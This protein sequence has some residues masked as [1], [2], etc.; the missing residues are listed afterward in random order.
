[1]IECPQPPSTTTIACV[2]D[3]CSH[4][5]TRLAGRPCLIGAGG[6]ER[7]AGA[8]CRRCGRA[9]ISGSA[10][11]KRLRSETARHA[12]AIERL[13][14]PV[15]S[16]G[17]QG[18]LRQRKQN[19]RLE[20]VIGDVTD[21]DL[22]WRSRPR[23]RSGRGKCRPA[24]DQPSH[25]RTSR[26]SSGER[27]RNLIECRTCHGVPSF[28]QRRS[29]GRLPPETLVCRVLAVVSL[30]SYRLRIICQRSSM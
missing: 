8:E 30:P 4:T 19:V 17:A 3:T 15:C 24:T 13:E 27:F 12:A 18:A 11:E 28:R 29:G 20:R 26:P 14:I 7:A 10:I 23:R 16:V 6:V 9:G 5:E 1:M 21:A 25:G 22:R 2:V